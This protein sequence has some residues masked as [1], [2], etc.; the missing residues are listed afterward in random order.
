M[1]PISEWYPMLGQF[2]F[3]TVFVQL[4]NNEREALMRGELKGAVVRKPIAR[5]QRVIRDLPGGCFVTTD[6]CAPT[7][8][9]HFG[10]TGKASYGL[11]AWRLLATSGKVREALQDGKTD[12]LVV[13]PYR[14]INKTREFRLFVYQRKLKGMSQYNLER[15]F[16]RLAGQEKTIWRWGKKFTEG[17]ADFLPVDN[18]AVDVYISSENEFFIIDLNRWGEP[19]SPLLFKTWEHDWQEEKGLKLIP[20]PVDMKGEVSVSF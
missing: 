6:V 14:R 15:H 3:P 13:R 9:E 10:K 17:I 4:R 2:S 19:T 7:D 1:I 11:T 5:L 16:H 12:R 20:Y 18:V 8:S